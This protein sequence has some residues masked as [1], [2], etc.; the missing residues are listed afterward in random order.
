MNK[1]FF[2]LCAFLFFVTLNCN[3]RDQFRLSLEAYLDNDGI[4]EEIALKHDSTS[5]AGDYYHL[6]VYKTEKNKKSRLWE[7]KQ[8]KYRFFIGDFGV[9]DLSLAADI[10]N[11][12]CIE[13]ISPNALSD[14]SP[15]A[16]R[17]FRW[18]KKQ[19]ILIENG[20]YLSRIERKPGVFDVK[21]DFKLKHD[22]NESI[23]SKWNVWIGKFIESGPGYIVTEIIASDGSDVM[24]GIAKMHRV[25]SG[26]KLIGWI[27]PLAVADDFE[28]K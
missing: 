17:I 9:E 18:T 3:A 11:D 7:D 19:F 15:Q 25:E 20:Y 23:L 12:N 22:Y 8:K 24:L 10:D 14:V 2:S 28:K 27:K 21:P 16:F 5:E 13:L 6:I 1:L 4:P 26:F